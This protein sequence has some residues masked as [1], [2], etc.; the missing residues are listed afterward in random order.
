MEFKE[1]FLKND[2]TKHKWKPP[3][4]GIVKHGGDRKK[5]MGVHEARPVK[6]QG[7]LIRRQFAPLIGK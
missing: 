2:L 1:W 5:G 7:H 6:P 3:Q 4:F